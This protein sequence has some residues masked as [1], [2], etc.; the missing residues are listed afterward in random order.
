MIKC[1][2]IRE[3]LIDIPKIRVDTF[4]CEMRV[5][6]CV[7]RPT[8]KKEWVIA[9]QTKGNSKSILR[10]QRMSNLII[11]SSGLYQVTKAKTKKD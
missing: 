9:E 1:L 5:R 7:C 3:M 6:V 4:S 10:F 8:D 2:N 11:S